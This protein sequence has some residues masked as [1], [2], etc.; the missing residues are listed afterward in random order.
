MSPLSPLLCAEAIRIHQRLSGV[1]LGEIESIIS[2][3]ADD[4]LLFITSPEHSI[5]ICYHSSTNLAFFQDIK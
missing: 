3:Y 5:P 4:V 2:P 1:K